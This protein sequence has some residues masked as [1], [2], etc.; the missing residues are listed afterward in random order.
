MKHY[1]LYIFII[2]ASLITKAQENPKEKYRQMGYEAKESGYSQKAIGHYLSVFELD[3][4]DYDA[5]LALGRLYQKQENCDS[6]LYFFR[7]IYHNDST[8]VEAM[9]GVVKCFINQGEMDS[10]IFYAQKVIQMMPEHVPAYLQ[11]AKALSYA[12]S[13]DKAISTYQQANAIDSTWSQVWAGI[14]KMY[15][16][17]SQPVKAKKYYMKALVLDPQNDEIKEEYKNIQNELKYLAN[18]KFQYLQEKEESYQIDAF[19]QQYTVKKRLTDHFQLTLNF[20]LDYSFREY[21][22]SGDTTRWYDNTWLKAS[23]ITESHRYSLYAGFSN[24]DERMSTYGISWYFKTTIGKIQLKNTMDAGYNYFYYWNEIGRHALSNKLNLEYNKFSMDLDMS[25][26]AVDENQVRKYYSDPL[27][28]DINPFLYYN[29]TFA[30]Q[31]FD[32][33]KVKL[34]FNHSYY[35]YKYISREYYTPNDRFLTGLSASV[36]HK[37]NGFYVYAMYA[38]NFGTEKYYYLETPNQ[39]NGKEVEKSG[40]IDANNWS[41]ALETGYEWNKWSVSAG[42][43]RFYNPYYQNFVGFLNVSAMF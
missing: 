38:Q 15:Y 4:T 42:A 32:K 17:K 23:W 26:G 13:L 2:F 33:P 34:A 36:F 27:K 12:G 16:W 10:A 28:T 11:L 14:G 6:S 43:S 40:S 25:G 22:N 5:R 1:C 35:D 7:L 30:W 41:A 24:S 29:F 9:N 39:A 31:I 37:F 8:D 18:S 3:S 19:I 21:V 20:L